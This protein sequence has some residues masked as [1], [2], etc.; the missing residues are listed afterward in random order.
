MF[1]ALLYFLLFFFP[2]TTQNQLDVSSYTLSASEAAALA[3]RELALLALARTRLAARLDALRDDE[4]VLVALRARLVRAGADGDLIDNEDA[5]VAAE[6]VPAE[7]NVR[8][9][10]ERQ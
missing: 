6:S 10:A 4:R 5:C 7:E 9:E 2:T 3:E 8:T 1:V